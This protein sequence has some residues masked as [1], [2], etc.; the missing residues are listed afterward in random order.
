MPYT[1]ALLTP[2]EMGQADRLAIES[3]V[4]SFRLME[5]AGKAVTE[6]IIERYYQRSVLVLCGTGNN[7]GDG[8]IV[9]RLLQQRGWPVQVRILGDRDT[10][11]GDAQVAAEQW[12]GRIDRPTEKDIEDADLVIDA[13]LGAGLDRDVDGEI[14]DMIG[15]VN[16]STLPVVSIDVPSG[17]DG[18]SGAV[19]GVAMIADMTVTFFRLKPGHLLLPG[20]QHCGEVVLAEIGIPENVLERILP[21]AWQNTRS[22]WSLPQAMADGHK[23]DRG[24]VIVVSG[25]ELETGGA[26]LAAYGAFRVG[27]GLVSI[28]GATDALRV[29]AA[30]M[31]AVML[32]PASDAAELSKLLEDKRMNAVVLGPAAGIGAETRDKTLSVLNSGASLVLDA[33][34]ISSFASESETLF[35]AIKANPDRVVVLTPHEGEFQRLFGNVPGG[36]LERARDAALHSGAVILLKGSDTVIAAPDGRA[37]INAN[38]PTWLGTAGAGDVLA[39]IIGGLLGQGMNGFEAAC[40][41]AW[42][43]AEAANRFGG[44]GMMSEDLPLLLPGI[45]ATL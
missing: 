20:R 10:L 5:A 21:R 43:H 3:G 25:S 32:K 42:L 2:Q 17:I 11:R 44:P 29:H 30:H 36:K 15:L 28:A 4:R 26:R 45:L 19:R 1:D 18:A 31:T 12:T 38:A 13:I 27:A 22:L 33:D 9:A 23:F 16:A 8:F 7:G 41:G 6:A 40:A 24:H 14:A 35:A 34:G 39:G 37:A